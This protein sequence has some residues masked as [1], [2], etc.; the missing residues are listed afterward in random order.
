MR[1][2]SLLIKPSGPDCNL[3]CK[4]CFYSCKASMFGDS[5]HR[6][7]EETRQKLI[8]DYTHLGF[9]V[10]SFAW[11]GGEPTLMGLDFYKKAIELQK[12]FC[13]DGQTVTNALQT[14]GV[15]LDDKWCTFL[16]EYKW[17]VGISVD[18]P[19]K[20]HD[21]YRLD[22]AG[23]GTFDR[24]MTAID[25]CRKHKVEFNILVLLN[26]HNV[27][28]PDEIFDFF[29]DRKIKFLQFI[30]CVE[31]D[32]QTGDIANFSISA[33]QYG[34]FLCRLFDRWIEFGPTKL[35][36]RL[37]DTV[38]TYLI[39]RRHV[40][41]TFSNKCSDY[42]VIEHNG[43]AF[44]CDFFVDAEHKLGNICDTPIGELMQSETKH[45]FAQQ[46]SNLASKCVIC[47]HNA[48][49]RG[50]CLKD[51]LIHNENVA[52][53]SCHCHA[54]KQFFDHALPKLTEIAAHITQGTI[55]TLR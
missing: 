45:R 38:L 41:C 33:E 1:Q 19:K 35:S 24:V 10:N 11:Q 30:P 46:K 44:C 54:Y 53:P 49:C 40:E 12:E 8:E 37:F 28:C 34:N 13:T 29:V 18:G 32:P 9:S 6:M 21:H 47:R 3:D 14:N 42:M 43:D 26:D 20:L 22:H 39:E 17:L 25:R 50:G 16:H 51:R 31:L 55:S 27:E 36:I 52:S 2:F 23:K 4:Y 5:A 7:S 15:L 48:I